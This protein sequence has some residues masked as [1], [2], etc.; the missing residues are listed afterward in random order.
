MQHTAHSVQGHRRRLPYNDHRTGKKTRNKNHSGA[1]RLKNKKKR[2]KKTHSL[3][4][5]T[6]IQTWQHSQQHLKPL[7]GMCSE[8]RE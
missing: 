2:R 7:E 3:T 8:Q 4:L 5:K 1:V 6:P